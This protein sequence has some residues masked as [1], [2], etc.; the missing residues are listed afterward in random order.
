[1]LVALPI[2]DRI[3]SYEY[4]NNIISH[5]QSSILNTLHFLQK[6]TTM[7]SHRIAHMICKRDN[8]FLFYDFTVSW[9]DE[10]IELEKKYNVND[11]RGRLDGNVL[12]YGKELVY[13]L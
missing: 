13:D 1:M 11:F 12:I 4:E 9:L 6:H 3:V 10:F 7:D 2:S 8:S 5:G